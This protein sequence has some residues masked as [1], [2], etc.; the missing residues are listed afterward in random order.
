LGVTL[1]ILSAI[2]LLSF[3]HEAW[4][5]FGMTELLDAARKHQDNNNKSVKGSVIRSNTQRRQQ[6]QPQQS[7]PAKKMKESDQK[8]KDKKGPNQK[9]NNHQSSLLYDPLQCQHNQGGKCHD[10]EGGA[11]TYRR[12]NG[13]CVYNEQTIPGNRDFIRSL[14]GF[15]SDIRKGKGVLDFGGGLGIYLTGFRNQSSIPKQNLVI[16]EP[17]NLG[18]C[19]L[20]GITQDT[21]NLVETDLKK[22][23]SGRFDMIMTIEVLEHIPVQHHEHLINAFSKL[24]NKW[25]VFSAAHPGQPGQGHVGP[26]MKTRDEWIAEITKRKQWV[27]DKVKSK[28]VLASALELLQQ[29]LV[30]FRK[31]N[32]NSTNS[33]SV[34]V[35]Q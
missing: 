25:L 28:Q 29:N 17:H 19:L 32:Y 35:L 26:S 23:P 6:K 15:F 7:S 20:K 33:T 16:M 11:W 1:A 14:P 3:Y 31:S 21:T 24:S 22:V 12:R 18:K 4:Q 10:D 30:V 5:D 34:T 8:A 9:Q 27:Y 2:F 13:G